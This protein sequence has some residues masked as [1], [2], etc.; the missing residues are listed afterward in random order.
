VRPMRKPVS[1]N[2]A[3]RYVAWF[4]KV[5]GKFYRLLSEAEWEY[6]ARAG[7]HTAY[8]WGDE[9][10]K[11]NAHCDDCG[12]PRDADVNNEN[13]RIRHTCDVNHC[14]PTDRR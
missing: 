12:S 9:I 4:S 8:S 1:W 13:I 5:T 11:G 7:T 10:G 2:D 14:G 3:Q 6:A